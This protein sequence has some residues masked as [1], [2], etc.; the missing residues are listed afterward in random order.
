MTMASSAPDDIVV[1]L[2]SIDQLF[3]APDLN[4]FSDK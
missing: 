2:D 1:V 3:N 4:P